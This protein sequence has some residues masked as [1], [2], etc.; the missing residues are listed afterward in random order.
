MFSNR[1]LLL[2]LASSHSKYLHTLICDQIFI[3]P[4]RSEIKIIKK[5]QNNITDDYNTQ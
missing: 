2:E 1:R 3:K 5:N 4:K